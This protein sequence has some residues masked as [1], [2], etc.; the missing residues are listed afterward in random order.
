MDICVPVILVYV[1]IANL[2]D[3]PWRRKKTTYVDPMNVKENMDSMMSNMLLPISFFMFCRKTLGQI[4]LE[5]EK[6]NLE[7][8]VMNGMS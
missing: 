3:N 2:I 8:L 6:G 4:V 5:K 7:Y 1:Y